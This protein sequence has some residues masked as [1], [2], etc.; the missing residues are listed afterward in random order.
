MET[1]FTTYLKTTKNLFYSKRFRI[2]Y[3][4]LDLK[5]FQNFIAHLSPKLKILIYVLFLRTWVKL[6]ICRS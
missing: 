4:S 5:T 2:L 6:I 3:L 1:K